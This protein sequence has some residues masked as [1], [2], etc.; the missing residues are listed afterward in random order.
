MI[1]RELQATLSGE[2]GLR[3]AS[4]TA[5]GGRKENQDRCLVLE[6]T[7][8]GAYL[9]AVADGMGGHRSGAQAAEACMQTIREEW[10]VSRIPVE[11]SQRIDRMIM[12]AH[13]A[14]KAL[15]HQSERR[16][17]QTTLAILV[18]TPG[19][20]WSGHV[21]DTRIFHYSDAGLQAR[22]RDHSVTETKLASGRISEEEA[23][24]DP[25]LNLLTQALGSRELPQASIQQWRPQAGDI[26]CLASDGAWS[27]LGDEDFSLL[28]A[29]CEIEQTVRELMSRKLEQAPAGQDNATLVL[30]QT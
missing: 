11:S 15:A 9:L 19:A 12:R 2:N 23:L 1:H 28:R 27:L 5:I 18:V 6:D 29:S 7:A 25:D 22:T 14:V 10:A 20:T 24:H 26:L 21:G 8:A 17:P 16:P 4:F 13:H 30:A 3:Y